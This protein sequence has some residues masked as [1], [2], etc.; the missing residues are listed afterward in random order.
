M[1]DDQYQRLLNQAR[2]VKHHPEHCGVL[3]TSE[4]LSVAV[5]LNRAD[6]LAEMRYTLADAIKRIGP[7]W[8]EALPRIAD[9]LE[10][11]DET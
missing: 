1:S 10:G 5:I 8:A 4:K 6:W 3:S 9:E 11:E 2:T 7:D